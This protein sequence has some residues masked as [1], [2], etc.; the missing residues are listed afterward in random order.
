MAWG[1]QRIE[2][3]QR[4]DILIEIRALGFNGGKS[5]KKKKDMSMAI[6]MAWWGKRTM[7]RRVGWLLSAVNLDVT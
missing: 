4:G 5:Y 1:F 2:W 3:V 7:G 6:R